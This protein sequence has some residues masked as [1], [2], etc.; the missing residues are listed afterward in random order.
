[1]RAENNKISAIQMM[2]GII[3]LLMIPVLF[4]FLSGDWLWVEGWLFGIW[5][6]VIST[7]YFTARQN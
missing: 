4:L 3:Y 1:M 2:L 7:V 6:I 5:L